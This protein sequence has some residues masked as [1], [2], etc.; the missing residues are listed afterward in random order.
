M[1]ATSFAIVEKDD[2]RFCFFI[3]V[4]IQNPFKSATTELCQINPI[5]EKRRFQ[6]KGIQKKRRQGKKKAVY[7]NSNRTASVMSRISL[8]CY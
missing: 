2:W 8:I 4:K 5:L 7:V 3:T 6:V 1:P